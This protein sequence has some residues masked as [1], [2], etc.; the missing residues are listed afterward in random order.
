MV[1][2][3][4][5][6]S[7]SGGRQE[8]SERGA[9]A[10][11]D[12]WRFRSPCPSS[13][14]CFGS[15]LLVPYCR[16]RSKLVS[17]HSQDFRLSLSV[18]FSFSFS[19]AS[20][21]QHLPRRNS[22]RNLFSSSPFVSVAVSRYSSSSSS[23][24]PLVSSPTYRIA[25][26]DI[27]VAYIRDVVFG[28]GRKR[29][30][31]PRHHHRNQRKEGTKQLVKEK[32]GE[33]KG[34]QAPPRR[35]Q[36]KRKVK[37]S[38]QKD[39]SCNN[40]HSPGVCTKDHQRAVSSSALSSSMELSAS[41]VFAAPLSSATRDTSPKASRTSF[42]SLKKAKETSFRGLFGLAVSLCSCMGRV[43][44][45]L[46]FFPVRIFG[47]FLLSP[48]LSY[49]VSERWREEGAKKKQRKKSSE[50]HLS[51]SQGSLSG[52][53]EAARK[54]EEEEEDG[55]LGFFSYRETQRDAEEKKDEEYERRVESTEGGDEED[56]KEEEEEDGQ[57][58][59]DTESSMFMRVIDSIWKN[60]ISTPVSETVFFFFFL[61]S[62]PLRRRRSWTR[63]L[64]FRAF[65]LHTAACI[66]MCT[67]CMCLTYTAGLRSSTDIC[68]LHKK[69]LCS[70]FIPSG[71]HSTRA[72]VCISGVRTSRQV[73][74]PRVLCLLHDGAPF[75]PLVIFHP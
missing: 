37:R 31:R 25:G 57:R 72:C 7:R 34:T 24:P 44:S 43:S 42:S 54:E 66:R 22:S 30:K 12:R 16:D 5:F 32:A 52:E 65:E 58:E 9:D 39:P 41:S 6:F 70:K 28:F 26:R 3:V 21:L 74:D 40:V 67:W 55:D 64:L 56:Q 35:H 53:G 19:P 27:S 4:S 61:L 33:T 13:S 47:R 75:C 50:L 48:W 49:R 68:G 51:S 46:S 11:G 71:R 73:M 45:C 59:V 8:S 18:H 62:P 14:S 1:V 10:N 60:E 63:C 15:S 29:A 36:G 20:E 38:Q 23:S 17:V 69:F 2:Y